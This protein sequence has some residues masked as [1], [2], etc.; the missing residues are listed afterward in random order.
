MNRL[1][2]C[3]TE[4]KNLLT[5]DVTY[6]YTASDDYGQHYENHWDTLEQFKQEVPTERD[7]I[8]RVLALETFDSFL[9]YNIEF[10]YLDATQ[11]YL[12]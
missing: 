5:A 6:G 12:T 2:I 3:V 9:N 8:K 11:P 7:L 1:V 10:D 4:F